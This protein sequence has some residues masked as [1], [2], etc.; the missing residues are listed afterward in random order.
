MKLTQLRIHRYRDVA[1]GSTLAFSPT[2]NLV[3][4]EN[5]T[6]RTT[7]L[8]LL[9]RA[10]ASDFSGLLHEEFSLEYALAFPGMDLHV[11]VRNERAAVAPAAPGVQALVRSQEPAS[12]APLDPFMELTI[13]LHAPA[14]RLVMRANAEGVSWEVDGQPA[15]SQN[16]YWSLLDRT[17]WVVLFLAAQRLA[18]E[19]KERLKE[20]LR[21]TFLLAPARFD[22]SLGMFERIGQSQFAMEMRGEDVF[23]LGLMSLPT[24]LPGVLRE[25]AA[26]ATT[27]GHIDV[28]HDEF[29]RSF[30][31]RFV[32]LAGLGAGRFR[33]ELL[34]KRSYDN[35]GRLEFGQFGFEFTRKDGSV[36]SR[37]H[38]SHGQKRLL[39]LLYYL[40]V[41]EDFVIADELA[42]GL[43]P[44]WVE[45][46]VREL[47]DRQSFLTSQNPLLFDYVSFGS[48]EE[49]H[50]S[51]I[52]CGLAMH[53]G[54]ERKAWTNPP[55]DVA[56]RLFADY[57]RGGTPLGTLL[58]LHG[59][60]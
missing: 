37:E 10:I 53:E 42:N 11:R 5:G 6:G 27:T 43:H 44:R 20:L 9:A 26:Q 4:G 1:P 16:M 33:V 30:L 7:L 55:A 60:W 45:G 57:A 36:L 21:H 29:D 28:R 8:D 39:S 40:D 13:Q 25:R 2:L 51:L 50:S 58:R 54:H 17:V 34:D 15:Y 49:L 19:L 46:C 18:P 14:A 24:W 59:L 52:H 23:P 56:A 48:Y 3:L 47:G 31:A 12:E 22:E 32:T 35:G 38:L 41:N